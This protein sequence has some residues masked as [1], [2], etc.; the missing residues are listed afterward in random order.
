[1]KTRRHLVTLLAVV[2]V[3]I[4]AAGCGGGDDSPTVPEFQQ[5]VVNTRD[6]VDFALSRITKAQSK[7]EWLNRMDEASAAISDA[8]GEFEEA[9]A[10]EQFEDEADKLHTSLN[11]LAVDLQATAHDLQQPELGDAL[12][13]G[14]QGLNFQSWDDANAALAAMIGDGIKVQLI[15]RH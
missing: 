9:G 1:V 8:S 12:G 15:G 11:Q 13:E 4:S 2:L 7:E 14:L 5:S 6:R 3:G 10:P